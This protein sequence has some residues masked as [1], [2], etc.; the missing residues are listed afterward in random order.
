MQP[1]GLC[2]LYF[3]QAPM[4]WGHTGNGLQVPATLSLF[5]GTLVI[6]VLRAGLTLG[7][8]RLVAGLCLALLTVIPPT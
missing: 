3:S 8:S 5:P 2:F 6:C 4:G 1:V 7:V